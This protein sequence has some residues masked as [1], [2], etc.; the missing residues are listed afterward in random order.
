MQQDV[1]DEQELN[2][3]GT[4]GSV[5]LSLGLEDFDPSKHMRTI[6]NKGGKQAYLDVRWRTLWF[7]KLYPQGVIETEEIVVDLDRE[8]ET[9]VSVWD[10]QAGAYRVET[11]KGR[12]YA[13]YRATAL[14]GEGGKG[15]GTKTENGAAFGDFVEKAETGAIG[16]ALA[17]LGF[18]TQGALPED[19]RLA[20]GP[21]ERGTSSNGTRARKA[22]ATDLG[23]I[24]TFVAD[25]CGWTMDTAPQE[26][27]AL[28]TR[29]FRAPISDTDLTETQAQNLRNY[30]VG[31]KAKREK[32]A[33]NQP[34]HP[35]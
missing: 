17:V 3:G 12:G 4:N 22:A 18:G 27:E 30:G 25:A 14:T 10:E 11:V 9:E 31:E 6:K 20:D 19:E 15:V 21:V 34:R 29:M 16:R 23:T 7:R 24:K 33:K 1:L 28:K 35:G 5:P 2:D 8:V 13:R 32:A 26:W